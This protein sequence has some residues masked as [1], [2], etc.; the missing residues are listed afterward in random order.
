M[1]YSSLALK[2]STTIKNFGFA[3]DV[4]RD[5]AS[6]GT[7][8][9]LFISSK[10][11]LHANLDEMD[12][13]VLMMDNSVEI[14]TGDVLSSIGRIIRKVNTIAPN[15]TTVIYYEVEATKCI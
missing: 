1:D 7:S 2:T 8:S 6:I 10:E 13:S 4:V 15:G 3:T 5:G 14:K 9:A 11:E 12:V